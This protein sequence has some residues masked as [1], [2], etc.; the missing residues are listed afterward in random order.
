MRIGRVRRNWVKNCVA[1]GLSGGF[2]EPL[3][4]TAIYV[5]EAAA[6]WLVRHFPDKAMSPVLADSFNQAMEK[7]Y[8][9]VRDFIQIHYCSSNRPDP[10]WVAA[11]SEVEIPDSLRH[12]LELWRHTFPNAIDTR[13]SRLFDHWNYLCVLFSKG[14]YRDVSLPLEG[15]TSESD[16]KDYVERLVENKKGLIEHLPDHHELLEAIRQSADEA[17]DRHVV[18]PAIAAAAGAFRST[19]PLPDWGQETTSAPLVATGV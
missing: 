16:W 4:S 10:F 1:I 15:S 14:Y 12:R 9:E 19:I 17:E 6:R 13:G 3:E 11:R 8:E 7:L 5:V 18:P 2:I